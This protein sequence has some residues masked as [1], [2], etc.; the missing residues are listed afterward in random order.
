MLLGGQHQYGDDQCSCDEHLYEHALGC[1]YSLLEEST[2]RAH[3][4]LTR[5]QSR[6]GNRT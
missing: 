6:L 2:A 4:S 3:V 5:F 1:I